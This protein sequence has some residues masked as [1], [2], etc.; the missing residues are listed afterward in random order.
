MVLQNVLL[1]WVFALTLRIWDFVGKKFKLRTLGVQFIQNSEKMKLT[2]LE[3]IVG[4]MAFCA[5]AIPSARAISRRFYD[6]ISSAKFRKS[7]Y[8]VRINHE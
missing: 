7:Y 8:Y 5:R 4:S 3:S 2:D 1:S 6:V